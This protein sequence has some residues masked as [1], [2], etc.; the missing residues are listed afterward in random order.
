MGDHDDK[1]NVIVFRIAIDPDTLRQLAIIFTKQ[2]PAVLQKLDQIQS[3][4]QEI[5]T[6]M[7]V[8][9]DKI[10]TLT[11]DVTDENT[12]IDSAVTLISGIPQLIK[13]A[14]TAALA[15]GATPAQLQGLTDLAAS[16]EAKKA[17]LAAAVAANTGTPTP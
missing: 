13:D 3:T 17:A 15:Q 8:L 9:D 10:A 4:L 2:D 5:K 6:T 11:Q 7:A 16:I 12:V 1:P 14:V